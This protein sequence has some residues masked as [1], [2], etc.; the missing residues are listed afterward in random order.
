MANDSDAGGKQGAAAG[1]READSRPAQV[2]RLK[3]RLPVLASFSDGP[4]ALPRVEAPSTEGLEVTVPAPEPLTQDELLRRFHALAREHAEVRDRELGEAVVL[5]D[6]VQVDVLGYSRGQLIPFS[7][8]SHFWMELAPQELLPGFA[9]AIAGSAVGDSLKVDLVLP[10]TYPVESLRGQPATF[11]VDLIAAREVR[12]PDTDSDEF[13][14]QL[15]RGDTHQAVMDSLADELLEEQ[16]DLL[17]L[18][19]QHLVLEQ[20]ASRIEVE[21]PRSLI[22][23]EIRRRWA[24]AEGEAVAEKEF[25][26]EEQQ[27][28]LGLWMKDPDTRAEVERRLR[29]GLALK[30]VAERDRLQLTSQKTLE[31]LE[32]SVVAFGLTVAELREALVDPTAAAQLK[33]VAWHLLAVEHVM[34]QA[35]V[36]FEGAG[37]R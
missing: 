22:D 6:D 23:E 11:V 1:L 5:G 12:M 20:L 26:V 13:L 8:R 34:N 27:E 30:A 35:K 2:V 33:N 25:S 9:D 7:I 29:A 17:W 31:L 18:E 32:G 24:A 37:E 10:G 28:A 3:D 19:A 21:L 36:R 14:R 16:A 4:V 15:G